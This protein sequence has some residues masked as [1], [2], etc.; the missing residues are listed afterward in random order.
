MQR[1]EVAK[2]KRRRPSL[3]WGKLGSEGRRRGK[4]KKKD[5]EK[6]NNPFR[7]KK[8]TRDRGK[9]EGNRRNRKKVVRF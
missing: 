1:G 3:I 7:I 8:D 4:A 5:R 6:K 9:I 2:P